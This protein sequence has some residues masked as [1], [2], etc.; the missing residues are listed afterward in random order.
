ME[1][2]APALTSLFGFTNAVPLREMLNED[3]EIED[4]IAVISVIERTSLI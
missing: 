2:S 1:N 4:I 3:A